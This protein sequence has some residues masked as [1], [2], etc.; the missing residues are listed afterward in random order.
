ML[1]SKTYIGLTVDSETIQVARV[2]TEG[3]TVVVEKLDRFALVEEIKHIKK[4][5]GPA[6][7]A[8]EPQEEEP[9]ET[10]ADS[11]FGLEEELGE[12]LGQ[13]LE[14]DFED[15]LDMADEPGSMS[16]DMA[17]DANRVQSNEMLLYNILNGLDPEQLNLGLNIASGQTIFQIIR[18]T[19]F[20]EVK[21][22]D[23]LED[24]ENKLASIHDGP[25][26]EDSYSYTVRE[27]GS[28]VLCSI[29]QDP[30]LLSLVDHTLELYTGKLMVNEILPDEM[31]LA[32]L[33]RANYLFED[34]EITGIVQ[35]GPRKARIIFMKGDM[36]WQ[37]SPVINEGTKNKNFLNTVFSK[38]LFQLDSGEVPNLDR[39][40]IANNTLGDEAVEFFRSNFP[41]LQIGEFRYNQDVISH[42]EVPE[43][44]VAAFT[45]TIGAAAAAARRDSTFYHEL[46]FVPSY[47]HDRQKIFKL[48]WH[49]VALLALIFLAPLVFNWFYQQNVETINGLEQDIQ[50]TESRIAALN[51]IVDETNSLS[52]ELS[53]MVGKVALLDSLSRGTREWS[54]KLDHLQQGFSG[55]PNTWLTSMTHSGAGTFLEGY[56]LYRNR[57]HEL[58]RIFD[59]ATLLN[60]T[61]ETVREQEI[62]RFSIVVSDFIDDPALYSPEQ[63]DNLQEIIN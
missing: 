50:R 21:K 24:L 23:L 47:V 56:S 36:I 54:V 20:K 41:D 31:I 28:L 10:D 38:I 58:V 46:S 3:K 51:P 17:E 55:V 53:L 44:S 61:R 45:T 42:E 29:D 8:A 62:Y 49:G 13:D 11:I 16:L 59:E 37:V 5:G 9:E 15:E 14:D 35:F 60:V 4:N 30:A 26:S 48:Q 27:D 63:P 6:P 7:S 2:R 39:I 12:E 52:E 33:A 32:G 22:G 18:D 19:N 43:E 25:V 1:G 40:I 34:H 57:I